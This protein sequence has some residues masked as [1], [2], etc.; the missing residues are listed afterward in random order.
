LPIGK[1]FATDPINCRRE[2]AVAVIITSLFIYCNRRVWYH[3]ELCFKNSER[4]PGL[5][6]GACRYLD[7]RVPA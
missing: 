5:N 4:M 1:I 2:L 7:P 6:V 3:C